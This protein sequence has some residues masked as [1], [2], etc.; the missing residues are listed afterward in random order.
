MIRE[1]SGVLIWMCCCSYWESP[2]HY[3]ESLG[4]GDAWKPLGYWA[5]TPNVARYENCFATAAIAGAGA[6]AGAVDAGQEDVEPR[7]ELHL[8]I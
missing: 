1:P 6:G 8:E 4:Y 2:K 7:N 5:K 3:V